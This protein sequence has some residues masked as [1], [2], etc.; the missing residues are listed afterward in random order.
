MSD[1]KEM[2][3]P[4][5]NYSDILSENSEKNNKIKRLIKKGLVKSKKIEKAE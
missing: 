3:Q 1:Y 2:N 4:E 5:G